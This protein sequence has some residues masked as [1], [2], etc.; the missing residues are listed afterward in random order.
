MS[1]LLR[2]EVWPGVS[3]VRIHTLRS[4]LFKAPYRVRAPANIR[5]RFTS[6]LLP[7]SPWAIVEE[8]V[9]PEAPAL[10]VCIRDLPRGSDESQRFA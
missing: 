5:E 3:E 6:E 1:S 9:C 2:K 10:C 8:G 4:V 7:V